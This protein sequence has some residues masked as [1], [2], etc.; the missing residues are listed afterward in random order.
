MP[1]R[2]TIYLLLNKKRGEITNRSCLLT[3][4]KLFP[5][6]F[7]IDRRYSIQ[8]ARIYPRA[9]LLQ[10]SKMQSSRSIQDLI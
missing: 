10:Y 2:A 4:V 6:R 1:H 9:V 7:Q 5:S 8:L 3:F